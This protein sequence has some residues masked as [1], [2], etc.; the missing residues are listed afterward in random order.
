VLKK[1]PAPAPKSIEERIEQLHQDIEATILARA[2]EIR[3]DYVG[4]FSLEQIV[5][6][7]KVRAFSCPCS[8]YRLMQ[9][10]K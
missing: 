5:H 4:V 10:Q 7:L 1:Q 3:K 6:D 9:E 2:A 8:Q